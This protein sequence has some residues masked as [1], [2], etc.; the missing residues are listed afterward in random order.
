MK[1]NKKKSMFYS[2]T[3]LKFLNNDQEVPTDPK[4]IKVIHE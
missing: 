3:F 4:R 2:I 1:I